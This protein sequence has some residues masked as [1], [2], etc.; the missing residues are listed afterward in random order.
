MSGRKIRF[1]GEDVQ[2]RGE[3]WSPGKPCLYFGEES[4]TLREKLSYGLGGEQ[5]SVAENAM[6]LGDKRVYLRRRRRAFG[7]KH[8]IRSQ[9]DRMAWVERTSRTTEF[10]RPPAKCTG[11][12]TS[13]PGCAEPHPAWAPMPPGMRASP[14]SLGSR[15]QC[16]TPPRV[17]KRLRTLSPE[18]PLPQFQ[19][20]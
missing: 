8:R 4:G 10:Q 11:S 7:E 17:K 14:T 5:Y 2:R 9:K 12:P 16:V 18:R 1:W 15:F 13:R 19:P 3:K 20:P 6:F